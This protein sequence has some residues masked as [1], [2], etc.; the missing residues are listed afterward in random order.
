MMI[1]WLTC[2][3]GYPR[4]SAPEPKKLAALRLMAPRIT[5]PHHAYMIYD[6]LTFQ[7][8]KEEAARI[9]GTCWEK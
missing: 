3:V 4:T 7:S 5:D 9:I 8:E 2:L 1:F 6:R